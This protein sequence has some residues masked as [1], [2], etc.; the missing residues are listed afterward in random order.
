MEWGGVGMIRTATT[1]LLFVLALLPIS[2]YPFSF[3]GGDVSS[4]APSNLTGPI[5]P[6]PIVSGSIA[7]LDMSTGTILLTEKA[8]VSHPPGTLTKLVTAMV[9]FDHMREGK[10]DELVQVSPEAAYAPGYNLLLEVGESV[11]FSELVK[12]LLYL[13]GTDASI[14]I[15]EH[16]S[17]SVDAFSAHMNAWVREQGLERSRFVN[18]HGLDSVNQRS[19]AYDLAAIGLLAMG[20]DDVRGHLSTLRTKI[21]IG[22]GRSRTVRKTNSFLW[23]YAG[24]VAAHSSYTPESGYS[25]V[26][27]VKKN[28]KQLLVVVLGA[29]SADKRFAS[30]SHILHYG[31]TYYD[32]LIVSPLLDRIPY[33]VKEGD[34]LSGIS[35]LYG[36]PLS[37][38]ME[39]N[40]MR[41]DALLR[42]GDVIWIV[43]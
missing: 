27:V 43:K 40:E 16:V 15:A 1:F 9:A 30:A 8:H 4:A 19:T 38:M 42:V 20:D 10:L 3:V 14:A 29:P 13:P 18:P 21:E 22:N 39:V 7:L 34:T 28:E 2:T 5:P 31:F 33:K 12:L 11:P 32:Q 37:V 23:R 41:E 26:A 36:V 17:G 6:P 25:L 35:V 24:S